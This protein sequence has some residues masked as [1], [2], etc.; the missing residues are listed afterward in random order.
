MLGGF[1]DS[2]G[3]QN[4]QENIDSTQDVLPAM[5][6]VIQI[7][8]TQRNNKTPGYDEISMELYK[9]ESQL[10]VQHLHNQSMDGGEN[11]KRLEKKHN[12]SNP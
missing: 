12:M 11:P 2:E 4:Y 9:T 6:E 3:L 7:L 1:N 8:K 10:L 5:E